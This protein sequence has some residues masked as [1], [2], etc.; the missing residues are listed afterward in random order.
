MPTAPRARAPRHRPSGGRL[1]AIGILLL[2]L[3]LALPALGAPSNGIGYARPLVG[4]GGGGGSGGPLTLYVNMTDGPAFVPSSLSAP[5]GASIV[6]VVTNLGSLDHSFSLSAKA[7][8]TLNR[9]WSPAQLDDWFRGNGSSLNATVGPGNTTNL[10]TV[11]PM[12]WAEGSFE[13]VSLVPY[14]F[15][16][17]MLG[18][19]NVTGSGGGASAFTID[20]K[21]S[22]TVLAYEEPIIQVNATS[23]PVTITAAVSNLGS[24]S[25]TWTVVPQAGVNLTPGNFTDYFASHTPLANVN[26]PTT[27]GQVVSVNLTIAKAGVYEFICEV[28]GH[29]AN[30]M[31]GYLYVG[32]LAPQPSAGP[33]TAILDPWVL[34]AGGGLLALGVLLAV[35]SAFVGRWPP[36]PPWQ[37]P[38]H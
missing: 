21:A 15:Q 17:G 27:V 9:S 3:G 2:L 26:I 19:L 16:A 28:P 37:E 29:F 11:V 24:V 30:G 6:I 14:Q 32:V 8:V 12:S 23:F 5:A 38:D 18:F 1:A 10:S 7:N 4:T 22:A 25:H 36:S 33:S 35:V 31:S 13:F 20:V 34:Y